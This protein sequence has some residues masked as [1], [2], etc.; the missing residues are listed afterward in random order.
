MVFTHTG[1]FKCIRKYIPDEHAEA[2]GKDDIQQISHG[3]DGDKEHFVLSI[4][5]EQQPPDSKAGPQVGGR[6]F[7]GGALDPVIDP[8]Y[9]DIRV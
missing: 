2:V 4:P 9:F 6:L 5:C 8:G 7:P 3:G 1:Y